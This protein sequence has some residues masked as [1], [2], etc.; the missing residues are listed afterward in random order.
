MEYTAENVTEFKSRK[1]SC[2]RMLLRLRNTEDKIQS[3]WMS[4]QKR[5]SRIDI[6]W[7]IKISGKTLTFLLPDT[8]HK[9]PREYRHQRMSCEEGWLS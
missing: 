9:K 1:K 2:S 4:G 5:E 3:Y 7:S 6:C 8:R